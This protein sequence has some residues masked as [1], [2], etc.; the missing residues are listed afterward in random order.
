MAR[1]K[2]NKPTIDPSHNTPKT[3]A[4]RKRLADSVQKVFDRQFSRVQEYLREHW[5]VKKFIQDGSN[6]ARKI[7]DDEFERMFEE[8]TATISVYFQQLPVEAT[9]ALTDAVEEGLSKG[10]AELGITDAQLI[11]KLN[12]VARDW[13]S[14]RAAE[15]VGMRYGAD[16]ALVPN[17]NARWV[18]GDTTRLKL[19]QVIKETFETDT[20][21][22][23]VIGRIEQV[24]VFARWRAEMIARTEIALA[25]SKGNLA[26]WKQ[27]GI[28]ESAQWFLSDDHDDN[29]GCQCED[30]DGEIVKTGEDFPSGDDS[31]PAH[32]NCWCVIIAVDIAG[33]DE[34]EAEADAEQIDTSETA[35]V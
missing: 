8:V 29:L 20:P 21:L 3:T 35:E 33:D 27:T 22:N 4:A 19:R 25:Q 30:N 2:R 28:V 26:V 13:S 12:R 16:G 10:I 32:P 14:D 15:M 9:E 24:G 18:I 6:R 1:R 7:A 31:P 34:Q 11:N 17:P 5:P 23:E